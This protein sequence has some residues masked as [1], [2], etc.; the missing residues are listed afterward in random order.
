MPGTLAFLK[1]DS[2]KNIF[3]VS[4]LFWPHIKFW[5]K[6]PD[7]PLLSTTLF[8]DK[9]TIDEFGNKCNDNDGRYINVLI[10]NMSIDTTIA[11]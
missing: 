4:I 6:V 10:V 2:G 11:E 9:K 1:W 7:I 5:E 3:V 8:N